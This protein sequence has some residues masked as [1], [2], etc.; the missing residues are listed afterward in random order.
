MFQWV[1][2]DDSEAAL[3]AECGRKESSCLYTEYFEM[4]WDGWGI[5]EL[6]H[7]VSDTLWARPR[8]GVP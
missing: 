6:Y 2:E 7:S 3:Q 4:E 1:E 5:V 8:D